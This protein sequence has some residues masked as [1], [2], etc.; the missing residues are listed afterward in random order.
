MK[1]FFSKINNFFSRI[2]AD[3]KFNTVF[4]IAMIAII[5]ICLICIISIFVPSCKGQQEYED[6]ADQFT[7]E[8]GT[9]V[10]SIVPPDSSVTE[11]PA[12]Q[13]PQDFD[14]FVTTE[15]PTQTDDPSAPVGETP[16]PDDDP[17]ATTRP[18]VTADPNASADPNNYTI[19]KISVNFDQLMAINSDACAWLYLQDSII[20]YPIMSA[21]YDA[22]GFY[23]EHLYDKTENIIGSLYI[24]IGVDKTFSSRNTVI[25]G[26][27]MNN[28]SMF[29]TLNKYKKQTYYNGNPIMQ[30]YTP[31]GVTDYYIYIFA[32]YETD[33]T[34]S[35]S[36][37]F[38]TDA[39]FENYINECMNKSVIDTII[40][41]TV[42]DHIVTLSTCVVGNDTVRMIV[43]G[44]LVPMD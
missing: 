42:N 9:E 13:T 38:P 20:N 4:I 5:V 21:P 17:Q 15:Q 43:Q 22:P 44:V 14:F 41:P 40:T 23:L 16:Q 34:Q 26:H 24:D 10:I 31:E 32:A 3:K 33:I 1:S 36:V 12:T 39:D 30:L 19:K 29:G 11:A 18:V 28:G 25:H 37:V 6:G 27:R 2:F 35:Y 7:S 8:K